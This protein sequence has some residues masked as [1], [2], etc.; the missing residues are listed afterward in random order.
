MDN[1]VKIYFYNEC[2]KGKVA[3]FKIDPKNIQERLGYYYFTQS[4][5]TYDKPK[6]E[7]ISIQLFYNFYI[8]KMLVQILRLI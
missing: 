8:F 1:F 6:D 5:V 4:L 3:N 2:E 7:I